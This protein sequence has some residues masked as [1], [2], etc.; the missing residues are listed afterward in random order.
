[1]HTSICAAITKWMKLGSL[2]IIENDF[3]QLWRL[4][5]PRSDVWCGLLPASQMVPCCC[6]LHS[7]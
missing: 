7:G 2:Y 6:V 3:S 1:M 5:S 4:E